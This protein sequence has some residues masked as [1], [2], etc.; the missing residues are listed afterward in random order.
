MLYGFFPL[1]MFPRVMHNFCPCLFTR[2]FDLTRV[3]NGLGE[4]RSGHSGWNKRVHWGMY[5]CKLV[6]NNVNQPKEPRIWNVG[7]ESVLDPQ[8][9]RQGMMRTAGGDVSTSP[10]SNQLAQWFSPELLA[11]AKAGQLA[12]MP[13]IST[14]Q[15][16][17][18]LEDLERL[19]Q[20]AAAAQ[21]ST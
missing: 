14:M 7:L 2:V 1:S 11:Q 12:G 13:A 3:N 20:A 19:Q 18:S 6:P 4:H 17:L 5:P 16:M 15:N 9:V 8:S 10:T 21:L